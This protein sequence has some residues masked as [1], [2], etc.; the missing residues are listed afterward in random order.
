MPGTSAATS[1][2]NP[3][4]RGHE[5][6]AGLG[7][8]LPDAER[9][10]ADE[11][12]RELLAA[13]CRGRGRDHDRVDAAQLA[14]ER[15]RVGAPGREVEQRAAARE[16]AGEAGGLDDRMLHERVAGLAALDER[17]RAGGRAGGLERVRD[18]RGRA[19]ATARD[20]RSAPSRS[21]GCPPRAPR[22][23]RRRRPR[24][25]RGSSR[26][27]TPRPARRGTSRRRSS[28]RGGVADGIRVVDRELEVRA[29][30]DDRGE[31]AQL[32]GRAADLAAQAGLA[33]ARLAVGD[34]RR[35]RRR[36]HRGR[37]PRRA[38]RSRG[39]RQTERAQI[40][41]AAAARRDDGLEVFG[42]GGHEGSFRAKRRARGRGAEAR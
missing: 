10:R 12:L 20:A 3:A 35:A 34:R 18:D 40:G 32:A 7:A 11:T 23:C 29:L 19:L 33:E 30:L 24:T 27:R 6:H 13:G 42:G 5:D 2:S 21:P 41:A 15:D 25:R 16:R 37:R 28:G 31:Q 26:P 9:E 4:P 17:E 38:A 39:R 22:R 8:E 14:V 36:R 1:A